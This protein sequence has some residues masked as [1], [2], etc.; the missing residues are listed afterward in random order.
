MTNIQPIP[1]PYAGVQFRSRLEA[2]VAVL[3]DHLNIAWEYEY[4]PVHI[5][6]MN[7]IYLPD[8][9]LPDLR[10]YI[11]VKG[12][13]D[14]WARDEQLLFWASEADSG[15]ENMWESGGQNDGPAK[16]PLRK[17]GLLVIGGIPR[18]DQIEARRGYCD[19]WPTFP[20]YLHYKGPNLGEGW[21]EYDDEAQIWYV[22]GTLHDY[23][24]YQAI[25]DKREWLAGQHYRQGPNAP[26]Q[27]HGEQFSRACAAARSA[28][29]DNNG[30]NTRW[31]L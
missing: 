8:F 20:M 27:G 31:G 24:E 2:R 10:C 23:S 21:F 4:E 1:S 16:D 28:K 26:W 9:W 19:N 30:R 18:P 3:L 11:E 12:G 15:L 5:P 22:A 25:L 29:F 6:Q 14:A 13:V 17:G 7:D